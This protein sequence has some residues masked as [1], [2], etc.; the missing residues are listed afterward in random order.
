MPIDKEDQLFW[1]ETVKD[2]TPVAPLHNVTS[3]NSTKPLKIAVQ[4]KRCYA[5]RQE[6]STYSKNLEDLEFGG[7][8]KATLRRFKREEFPVEA[9]LDLHGLTEDEAFEKVD[10]FVPLCF[11]QGKRCVVIITGKGLAVHENDDIFTTKGVLKRQV[12]Q[13]LNMSRLRALILV[14][15]HPSERLGGS[16]ALYILLRRNKD[17]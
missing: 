3:L 17:I 2:I 9:T 16:G 11:S 10:N 6:F 4:P 12:P 7:I 8:D 14:Y 5:T 1:Q 15:K 13:W